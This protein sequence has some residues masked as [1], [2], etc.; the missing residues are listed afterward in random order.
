MEEKNKKKQRFQFPSSTNANPNIY[1]KNDSVLTFLLS[2]SLALVTNIEPEKIQKFFKKV[3]SS[4]A[5]E[6]GTGSVFS[7]K[8]KS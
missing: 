4:E 5:L 2:E 3:L 7:E 8:T 1:F 6:S